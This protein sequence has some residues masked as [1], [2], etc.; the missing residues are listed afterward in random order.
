MLFGFSKEEMYLNS[1]QSSFLFL[2]FFFSVFE[3][4][5]VD[6]EEQKISGPN[7][8]TLPEERIILISSVINSFRRASPIFNKL[9]LSI[10]FPS[11]A[12]PSFRRRIFF[13]YIYLLYLYYD[14]VRVRNQITKGE[15]LLRAEKY[16]CV[17]PS[18]SIAIYTYTPFGSSFD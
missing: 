13:F 4:L 18:L 3:Y 15:I 7:E 17:N 16:C 1:S 5:K 6:I 2:L 8:R 9:S 11:T 12:P 10:A 14:T